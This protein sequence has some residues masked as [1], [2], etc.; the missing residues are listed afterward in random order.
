MLKLEKIPRL[1]MKS[2]L[3]EEKDWKGLLALTITVGY[4]MLLMFQVPNTETLGVAVGLIVGW[5]FSGKREERKLSKFKLPRASEK[6]PDYRKIR[7]VLI[8]ALKKTETYNPAYD[9]LLVGEIAKTVI[10]IRRVDREI[11]KAEN[12]VKLKQ[13]I[14]VK[15][16][17][18][19]MLEDAVEALAI[20]RRSRLRRGEAK[21]VKDTMMERLKKLVF[22]ST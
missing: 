1:R 17:L 6:H 3:V 18:L 22:E 14:S 20:S 12:L 9:D 2:V 21:L 19:E 11:D 15:A 13:A 8:E 10:D 16:T 7:A 4:I 5:Y